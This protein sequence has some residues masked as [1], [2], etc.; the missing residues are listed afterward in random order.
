MSVP[1]AA[2]ILGRPEAYLIRRQRRWFVNFL[3]V[4]LVLAQLGVAVHASTHLK[5][6]LHPG[7][8]L[9][10]Q[11]HS[12]APLQSM[13]GGGALLVAGVDAVRGPVIAGAT[14]GDAPCPAFSAF[15]SRA[16]PA[17]L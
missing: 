10:G 6:D 12:N 7:T 14:R 9:C 17:L 4:A 8:Q 16:P 15:R 5:F 2:R 1:A 11:C 13:V 3:S